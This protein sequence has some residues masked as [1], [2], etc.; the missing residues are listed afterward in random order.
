VKEGSV[1]AGQSA[2][3]VGDLLPVKEIVERIVAEAEETMRRSA[4]LLTD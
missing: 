1:M 2:G 3:L 4:R